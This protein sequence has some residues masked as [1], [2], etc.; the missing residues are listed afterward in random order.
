MDLNAVKFQYKEDDHTLELAGVEF[1]LGLRV[2]AANVNESGHRLAH[3]WGH[4]P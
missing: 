1:F 4:C 2:S 3:Y